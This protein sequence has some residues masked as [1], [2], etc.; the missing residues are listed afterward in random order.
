MTILVVVESGAKGPKIE[1][2]LGKGY[3]VQGCNG[4]M[5][6][7][8]HNLKWIKEHAENGWDPNTIPYI[9]STDSKKTIASLRKLAKTASKVIIA[10]D[11]DREGEAI[12]FHIKD[13][14]KLKDSKMERIVFDQITPE[15]IQ[16]AIC[17]PTE[18]REPLYRAQQARRVIDIIFGYTVSPLLWHIQHKLSAGRC[19]SPALRWIYEKQQDF[20]KLKHLEAKHSVL[21]QS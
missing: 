15:A 4:H 20:L 16:H 12:G 3:K 19:Q 7:I 9:P 8:P 10:S 11:M 5:Q 17:H 1:K 13:L 2:I 14:L 6:D 18:L 21:Q